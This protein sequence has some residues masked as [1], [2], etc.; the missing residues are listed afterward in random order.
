MQRFVAFGGHARQP[1]GKKLYIF[2]HFLLAVAGNSML[3]CFYAF[4]LVRKT[5]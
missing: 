1:Q 2:Q 4:G 3:A 5:F